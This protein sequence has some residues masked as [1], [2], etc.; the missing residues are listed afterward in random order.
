MSAGDMRVQRQNRVQMIRQDHNRVDR[1]GRSRRQTPNAAR[2]AP[3]WSISADERRLA[4]VTV[5]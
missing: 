1:N 2:N 3:M 5:K 4:S